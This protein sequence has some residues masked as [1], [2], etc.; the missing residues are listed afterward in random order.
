MAHV[1][2]FFF[3]CCI[4]SWFETEGETA[5]V[6]EMSLLICHVGIISLEGEDDLCLPCQSPSKAFLLQAS[7]SRGSFYSANDWEKQDLPHSDVSSIFLASLN[8]RG[9][10]LTL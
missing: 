10:L 3:R 1:L 4:D 8:P 5:E 9:Q 7:H 6:T 2:Y